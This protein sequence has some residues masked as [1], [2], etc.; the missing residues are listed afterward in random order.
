[1]AAVFVPHV[2]HRPNPNIDIQRNTDS[3]DDDRASRNNIFEP[4]R[5]FTSVM[6]M[7]RLSRWLCTLRPQHSPVF[8]VNTPDVA[9]YKVVEVKGVAHGSSVRSRFV[10]VDMLAHLRSLLGGEV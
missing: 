8:V 1:M 7:R 9:G 2:A 6:Q 3:I 5:T 10:G 4:L